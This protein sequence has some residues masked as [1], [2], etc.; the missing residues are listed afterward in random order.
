MGDKPIKRVKRTPAAVSTRLSKDHELV[1]CWRRGFCNPQTYELLTAEN[2][3]QLIKPQHLG[4][5]P[6][7]V[8]EFD[9]TWAQIIP[10]V[11][12]TRGSKY[13]VYV[14]KGTE[15]RLHGK[16]SLGIGGHIGVSDVGLDWEASTLS[17]GAF[18]NPNCTPLHSTVVDSMWR[19]LAEELF[20][21]D[22]LLAE[23]SVR[24]TWFDAEH[25]R[26]SYILKNYDPETVEYVHLGIVFEVPLKTSA[27][28]ILPE[29][30]EIDNIE[31]QTRTWLKKNI[32][33]FEDWSK[34]IIQNLK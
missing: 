22:E 13:A 26:P 14:R 10:Y 33:L 3:D 23:Q 25:P 32:D 12:L 34:E 7:A 30:G 20:D 4:L 31:F 18:H 24:S 5:L 19:E 9:T 28:L 2:Y 1:L 16:L 6:R 21:D 11:V 8:C 29:G 17:Q 27:E 15:T